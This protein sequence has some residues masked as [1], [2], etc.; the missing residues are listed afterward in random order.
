MAKNGKKLT[1]AGFD[2]TVFICPSI[3]AQ[4]VFLAG[5][6]NDWDP[7][8]TPMENQ[9]DGS[10]R[11]EMELAPGRYEYKF[12][13]DGAWCCEPGRADSDCADCVP[14]DF[15]TMNR[16]IE[17]PGPAEAKARAGA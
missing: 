6:F 10:W 11:A 4:G 5:S 8:R 3:P 15:G 12:I 17:V 1:A 13:V 14:N 2:K 7:T 16:V 9:S